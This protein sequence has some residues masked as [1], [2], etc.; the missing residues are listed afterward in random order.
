[1]QPH[2]LVVGG[3]AIL[4][5]AVRVL[6]EEGWAV[7]VVSR[8]AERVA[9]ADRRAHAVIADVTVVDDLARALDRA[10]DERGPFGLALA[11]QPAAPPEAWAALAGRV[12]GVLVALLVSAY[13]APHG[14]PA[15]PLAEGPNGGAL[16]RHLLLGW[17]VE[18]GGRARWHRPEEIS[19]AALRTAGRARSTVLGTV[20]P[21]QERPLH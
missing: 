16:V 13:A 2:V 6:A 11:Y 19:A 14:A 10:R 18:D 7:S 8:S 21:W 12:T 5:P 1:M 20:R 15:P 3:T 9:A 4:A 17:H